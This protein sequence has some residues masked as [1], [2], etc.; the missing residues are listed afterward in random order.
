MISSLPAMLLSKAHINRLY[1]AKI[2]HLLAK[3]A[4]A[5]LKL[6]QQAI[7]QALP[8][9]Y[10]HLIYFQSQEPMSVKV[11]EEIQGLAQ[12]VLI[13]K[14]AAPSYKS[15]IQ[16]SIKTL[17]KQPI[18]GINSYLSEGFDHSS[19]RLIEAV[20]FKA[21]AQ[22]I[23]D[24]KFNALFS[25]PELKLNV[26]S[27]D[28][29]LNTQL[30]SYFTSITTTAMPFMRCYKEGVCF[31]FDPNQYISKRPLVYSIDKLEADR[32]SEDMLFYLKEESL[33]NIKKE[34]FTQILLNRS[35]EYTFRDY[36]LFN[37]K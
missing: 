36:I 3:I 9:S 4:P 27:E 7:R 6:Q 11:A 15:K 30:L 12:N 31:L 14:P 23:G 16:L 18:E 13:K 21:I 28:Y 20:Y 35:L 2:D 22:I 17:S 25:K 24:A 29:I 37:A 19:E 32:L 10:F 1:E 5:S 33:D 8:Q 26:S 34:R